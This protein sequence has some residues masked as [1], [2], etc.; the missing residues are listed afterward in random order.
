M[1]FIFDGDDN[2]SPPIWITVDQD[3][4]GELEWYSTS[5]GPEQ[6]ISMR[7]LISVPS[8]TATLSFDTYY[9][10]EGLWDYGMVQISTD[11]GETWISLA[12]EHTT[13]EHDP[14]AYPAI[15]ENL[16]GLTGS[17][18]WINMNFD[19]TPYAGQQV[20][21][22]FRYMTDWGTENPGWWVDNVKINDLLIDDAD[23][24]ISFTTPPLPETDFIVSI[25]E[26][27]VNNDIPSYNDVF[28]LSLDDIS[29]TGSLDLIDFISEDGYLLV[30]VSP[31]IGP[32]DYTYEI[33]R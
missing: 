17:S 15:I 13:L 31:T 14:D 23:D 26:V 11:D 29:E 8:G 19:I 27:T 7:T 6:D 24:I 20:L 30:I 28:E 33:T 5:A 2:A 10:I 3:G 16:P 12:N 25:V 21:L 32:V 22:S 9:D 1:Q 4:D 18:D